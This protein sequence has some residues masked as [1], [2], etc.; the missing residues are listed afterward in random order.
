MIRDFIRMIVECYQTSEG[1]VSDFIAWWLRETNQGNNNWENLKTQLNFRYEH[2]LDASFAFELLNKVN[3]KIG[4]CSLIWRK[5]LTLATDAFSGQDI[6]QP[7]VQ[8]FHQQVVSK[9]FENENDA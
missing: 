1:S 9:L 7:F 3:Q 8:L 2:I 4:K 6:N 5:I